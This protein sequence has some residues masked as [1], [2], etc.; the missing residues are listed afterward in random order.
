MQHKVLAVVTFFQLFS[1][2]LH[3]YFHI[4]TSIKRVIYPFGSRNVTLGSYAG[5]AGVK[6]AST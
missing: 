2:L 6:H 3:V 5:V 4:R 1:V